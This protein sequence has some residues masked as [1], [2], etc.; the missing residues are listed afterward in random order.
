MYEIVAFVSFFRF[1]VDEGNGIKM[2]RG[3]IISMLSTVCMIPANNY[4]QLYTWI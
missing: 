4:T 3:L 2:R 1:R